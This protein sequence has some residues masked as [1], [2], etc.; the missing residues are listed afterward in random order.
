MSAPALA[1][2]CAS[3]IVRHST[4]TLELKPAATLASFTAAV[5]LPALHTVGTK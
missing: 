5:M 2:S 1:A 4:S 3:S